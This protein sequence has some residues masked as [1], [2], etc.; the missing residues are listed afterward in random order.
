LPF[1]RRQIVEQAPWLAAKRLSRGFRTMLSATLVVRLVHNE[2]GLV[3]SGLVGE[4]HRFVAIA[5]IF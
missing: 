4:I 2:I 5:T 3:C 1:H